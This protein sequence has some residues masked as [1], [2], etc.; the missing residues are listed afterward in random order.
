[1]KTVSVGSQF[2]YTLMLLQ[3]DK[4]VTLKFWASVD[5]LVSRPPPSSQLHLTAVRIMT[6]NEERMQEMH[7]CLQSKSL[8]RAWPVSLVWRVCLS[9]IISSVCLEFCHVALGFYH[10]VMK[11]K[12]VER[13]SSPRAGRAGR[14]RRS[15]HIHLAVDVTQ[16]HLHLL[17][18]WTSCLMWEDDTSPSTVSLAQTPRLLKWTSE[19]IRHNGPDRI[20]ALF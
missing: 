11:A 10:E 4:C 9:F 17:F 3:F 16:T 1:M 6:S 20:W 8:F 2:Y 18:F 5:S 7:E 12:Q 19:Q 13:L 15:Y 14:R